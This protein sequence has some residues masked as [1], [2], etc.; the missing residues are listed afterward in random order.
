MKNWK[1]VK[2]RLVAPCFRYF[3]SII[4][5]LRTLNCFMDRKIPKIVINH[6]LVTIWIW[7][8]AII[9]L[10][11]VERRIDDLTLFLLHMHPKSDLELQSTHWCWFCFGKTSDYFWWIDHETAILEKI[12]LI[13]RLWAHPRSGATTSH[14]L[15][16]AWN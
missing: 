6:F 3:K 16:L 15:N 13:K 4:S 5:N 2:F 7:N 1:K 11:V 10:Y 14:R 9:L 12:S 8:S